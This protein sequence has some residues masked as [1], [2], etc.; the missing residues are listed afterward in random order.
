MGLDIYVRKIIKK[1]KCKDDYF[2]MLDDDLNYSDRGF[3]A[4]TKSFERTKT[5]TFYDWAL[6]K[7]QTGLDLDNYV[8]DGEA[9]TEEGN[10]MF[11][12]PKDAEIPELTDDNYDE[13]KKKYDE[14]VV[15]INLDEVPTYEKK[16]KILYY[17]EVGYQRK[18]LNAKFYEDCENGRFDG[19]GVV[20][21]RAELE[22]VMDEYCGKPYIYFYPNGRSSGI[23]VYPK[24]DFKKNIL[25]VF[26]EGEHCVKFS[27]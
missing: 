2:K 20:W 18:G 4:W 26:I 5:E 11:V 19:D 1:P 3:P 6:Y 7:Q 12:Y 23:T 27:W 10:F 14:V 24:E 25:D 17:E 9:Y 22:R 21:T 16:V 15:R 13:W 8:W